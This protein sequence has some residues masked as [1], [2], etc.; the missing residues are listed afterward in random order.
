MSNIACVAIVVNVK[1][2]SPWIV[3][4]RPGLPVNLFPR[5]VFLVVVSLAVVGRKS[6]QYSI[7][8]HEGQTEEELLG[9][10]Y[11]LPSG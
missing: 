10:G 2:S 8:H 1:W 3:W 6:A 4:V 5:P 7:R 11:C 9:R